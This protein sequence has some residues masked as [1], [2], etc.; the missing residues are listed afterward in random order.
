MNK[1]G[2][3]DPC[4]CGSG[5]KY[6]QCCLRLERSGS[7]ASTAARSSVLDRVAAP[8]NRAVSAQL[9]GD[10]DSAVR[11]YRDV[12]A[13]VPEHVDAQYNLALALGAQ[14]K[15]EEAAAS[16]RGAL[17]RRPDFVEARSNLGHLLHALGRLDEAIDCYRAALAIKPHAMIY[18]NLGYAQDELG[19]IEAALSSYRR[20]LELGDTPDIRVNFAH[21]AKHLDG[22][23]ADASLCALIAR[24]I[25]EAWT[26]PGDLATAAVNLIRT[27]PTIDACI[28]RASRPSSNRLATDD[29][30]VRSELA[31]FAGNA[32][33]ITLLENAPVCDFAVE[34]FLTLVRRTM[35]DTAGDVDAADPSAA[36][37][38]FY[39]AVARQCYLNEYVL[40][41]DEGELARAQDLRRAIDKAT[42]SN[43]PIPALA[44]I[45][46][47]SYAPLGE[48]ES[49]ARL[50]E[51]AW[52]D[53]VRAIIV[54]QIDEPKQEQRYRDDMGRMT[55]IDDPVSLQVRQQYEQNPYPRWIRVPIATRVRRLSEYLR[56]QFP[57]AEFEPLA[58]DDAIDVLIAGCGTGQEAIEAARQLTGARVV[59][60]DLSVASLAYAKRKTIEAGID[61]V[62]YAQ[63]DILELSSATGMFDVI[64]SVGVL[65]HLADPMTGW[66]ALLNLLRPGGFMRIGLYSELARRDVVAARAFIAQNGYASTAGDIRR[67]RQDLV[68]DPS[69]RFSRVPLLRDFY[70]TSECRDLL[71]HVQEH[72]FSLPDVQAMLAAL[73]LRFVGFLLDPH[74]A[75][76]YRMH[77]PHDRALTDLSAWNDFETRFPDTFT[78]MYRF[79]VQKA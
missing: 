76:S 77:F 35:L 65:H 50:R 68:G 33:L 24:A 41:C 58:S 71:F 40:A 5:R 8:Y 16:Y 18:N 9:Q 17:A 60:I 74:V 7:V 44:L 79:W 14:G 72:R 3:N 6:K 34:R 21:C 26:R 53:A 69:G 10:L 49:V 12:L 63:A 39:A 27:D 57:F 15:L 75:R 45:A 61:N 78:G 54:Q 36:I 70:T 29:A 4:P 1:V 38:A 46:A 30:L 47:A 31:A 52:P 51:R 62:R 2:R 28:A 20:A 64:T 22:R 67:A 11:G 66:R 13:R 32:L 19:Q 56:Q 55:A 59:A 25:D 23:Q 37:V 43:K 48:L 42:A 73:E